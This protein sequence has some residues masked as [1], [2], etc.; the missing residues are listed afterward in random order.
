MNSFTLLMT[1]LPVFFMIHDFEEIL[2]FPSWIK[3]NKSYLSDRFPVLSK[4]LLPHIENLSATAFTVAVSGMFL[5]ICML[6]YL[7]VYLEFPYLWLAAFMG[8]FI[9]LFLHIGQ[10]II[11]RRYVPVIVTS[12][13]ALPYCIHS[14]TI[15]LEEKLF[16]VS[17]I[18]ICSAAGLI[19]LLPVVV[20]AHKFGKNAD[21]WING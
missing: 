9:H 19:V 18:I 12:F 16:S 2:F 6:T 13:L 11:I 3:K 5:L 17:E 1:L 20:A 14:F 21:K 15:I 7:S 8:F 4:S 10:W